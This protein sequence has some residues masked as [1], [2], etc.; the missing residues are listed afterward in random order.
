M[1]ARSKG[2]VP[3][4]NNA[5][6]AEEVPAELLKYKEP[7]PTSTDAPVAA[8]FKSPVLIPALEG[9]AAA[10]RLREEAKPRKKDES[11]Y[12]ATK[13]LDRVDRTNPVEGLYKALEEDP[14]EA[15]TLALYAPYKGKLE[16]KLS[17][18]NYPAMK[19]YQ[20]TQ[21]AIE[22]NVEQYATD[23]PGDVYM[24]SSRKAFYTFVREQ[25]AAAFTLDK[26]V[27]EPDPD[28]CEALLK[29]GPARV[30][31]FKYQRFIKE[32]I[33]QSS[34]YRGILVYHGLGSGKTCSSIAAAEALY[35]IA[36]KRVI[37]MTPQ[38]LRDN[39]IK[40]ISFC[41]FRH[42]SLQNHWTK[43][44]LLRRELNE[45]TN[46][47]ENTVRVVHE[48][49]GRTTLSLGPAY[50]N[51]I[52]EAA[53]AERVPDKKGR[54]INAY[55]WVP[56]FEK[57]PNFDTDLTPTEKD[58]VKAQLTET[59]NNRFKFISYNGITNAQLKALC[60]QEG[61]FDN[62]VI[63]ID[64]VHNLTR[65]MRGKIEPFL[66]PRAKRARTIKVEPVTPERWKPL[67]CK[68]DARKKYSRGYMFYRLLVGA[69]NSKIV[70]LSGTP[71]INFPEELGVL[72]NILA[73]YID[74]IEL[75]VDTVDPKEIAKFEAIANADSRI[76]FVRL[77]VA[78]GAYK[79][80]LSVF[81]EGYVKVLGE[82]EEG[83]KAGEFMGVRH[84]SEK[85]GQMGVLEVAQRLI[86]TC[87]AKGITIEPE[88]VKYAS[89]PRLPPDQESFRKQF[90]DEVNDKLRPDNKTVLQ[91]R[92]S[93]LV[94]YYK[95]AKVD[96][97]PQV[98]SDV[99]VPCDFSLF[100]QG[101]YIDQR[102]HEIKLEANKET[103]DKAETLYA[104]VEA[105]TKAPNPSSY[106]FRSRA[107]CNFAFP[108]ARPYPKTMKELAKETEDP[109]D[110]DA[111]NLEE[112]TDEEI[113]VQKKAAKDVEKEDEVVD[114][115]AVEEGGA[116]A[117]KVEKA[118]DREA[119]E[120]EAEAAVAAA[121]KEPEEIMKAVASRDYSVQK[122]VA[123]RVLNQFADRYLK[124]DDPEGL[125]KY[126][127][128]LYEM[129]TRIKA[130]PGPSLVYSAFE[131]LEGLGV[132]TASLKANGYEEVKFNGKWYGKEPEFTEEAKESLRK[133]PDG[134]KRFVAFTGK[135]DRRQRRV[136]LAMFNNQWRDVPEGLKRFLEDECGFNTDPKSEEEMYLHG[137]V[138][139]CIGITG[140][141]AE[142][143]SLRNVRQVHIMEPF[144]N[145]VRLEQ[146]KGRAIRICSHMDLPMV[147]R[148][149]D[150]FTYI[151][152]FSADTIVKRDEKALGIPQGIQSVDGFVDAM[153][154]QQV[155]TSDQ[156]VFDIANRKEKIAKEL[157]KLMKEVAVDC[158]FN[159]ADNEVLQ[160][161]T[162][163]PGSNPYM[164][165]PDLKLDE[166]TTGA[167]TEKAEEKKAVV[168][169][170]ELTQGR[171]VGVRLD[172]PENPHVY[173]LIG[174]AN[175][176]TGIAPIYEEADEFLTKPI[177]TIRRN[178]ASKLGW[179][180]AKR[181]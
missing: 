97:L 70:G 153:K 58:Q 141:G 37:V 93:G 8:P 4:G 168:E 55:L 75:V 73:G 13:A 171:V 110:L 165:D 40:E 74:C 123:M 103:V 45:K 52:K 94:S 139:Q 16:K 124:L 39:F 122:I 56:D 24:P 6:V 161:L 32:Y 63:V 41:G 159:V 100:A 26:T 102:S 12:R 170:K 135:V 132:L 21:K 150:I 91:K 177:G 20:A 47:I 169:E 131:E 31:P 142:G 144:W 95:G 143:I 35:G 130:S 85:E 7:P 89:Y 86:K 104:A 46:R 5:S 17:E 106:R 87:S 67:L 80:L 84:T 121:P 28:A 152:Q 1:A 162:V 163:E 146:V 77:E 178:P 118:E 33:R 90:V 10:R 49:Y 145:L 117:E 181:L 19:T 134:T 2:Y 116:V 83:K 111:D 157:L 48:I 78:G 71:L 60:C 34:P 119:K 51:R 126:S 107:C 176:T 105:F 115:E 154:E 64:E 65:L 114:K 164:F 136:I 96:F 50:L 68:A 109:E 92:L 23:V 11:I 167:E 108:F 25:F 158:P 156:K 133:G 98:T 44:P 66:I 173:V 18:S 147:E 72:T 22:E 61:S 155:F 30:E 129:L 62:S 137:E 79:A 29:G 99:V 57:E 76:D 101:K 54:Y 128:K 9:S 42:F 3:L 160:C 148:K 36:N 140:A 69:R 59:I 14:D 82:P 27:A 53:K 81:Q 149:V 166:I 151:S 172:G 125:R 174:E 180:G 113:M 175:E 15:G 88:S 138:V 120:G 38:S 127:R 43:I 112:K 179:S